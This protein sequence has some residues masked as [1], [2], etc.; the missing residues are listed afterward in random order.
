MFT[1]RA[2][3]FCYLLG[4]RVSG[5]EIKING[6]VENTAKSDDVSL[7]KVHIVVRTYAKAEVVRDDAQEEDGELGESSKDLP[8]GIKSQHNGEVLSDGA[9]E[10]TSDLQESV[11]VNEPENSGG[12]NN[13]NP[14]RASFISKSLERISDIATSAWDYVTHAEERTPRPDPGNYPLKSGDAEGEHQSLETGITDDGTGENDVYFE[15]EK[16]KNTEVNQE[17]LPKNSIDY[18]DNEIQNGKIS[19]DKVSNEIISSDNTKLDLPTHTIKGK[20]ETNI[21]K[22]KTENSKFKQ[23]SFSHSRNNAK[24]SKVWKT[25]KRQ[26]YIS[27]QNT[28]SSNSQPDENVNDT[29]T[30]RKGSFNET[31]GVE[32]SDESQLLQADQSSFLDFFLRGSETKTT[33]ANKHPDNGPEDAELDDDMD[34][35]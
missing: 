24:D 27:G 3:V 20:S 7:P 2:L 33:P 6:S 13:E 19:V 18:D 23:F 17:I 25:P 11:K 15:D 8:N 22:G 34:N 10:L 32:E 31:A 28:S 35:G 29:D 1:V 4:C 14:S 5:D 21:R 26:I 12:S 9:S 30:G 16:F